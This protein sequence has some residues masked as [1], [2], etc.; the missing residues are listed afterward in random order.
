MKTYILLLLLAV[1]AVNGFAQDTEKEKDEP[2]SPGFA[3]GYLIDNQTTS[4]IEEFFDK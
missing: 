2:V 4:R 1:F 3:S